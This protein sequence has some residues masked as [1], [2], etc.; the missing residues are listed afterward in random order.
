[1]NAGRRWQTWIRD[2]GLSYSQWQQQ[3]VCQWFPNSVQLTW[4]QLCWVRS[5]DSLVRGRECFC[6]GLHQTGSHDCHLATW[7]PHAS[8]QASKEWTDFP[9]R[10]SIKIIFYLKIHRHTLHSRIQ[11]WYHHQ[12]SFVEFIGGTPGLGNSNLLYRTVSLPDICPR[13][14]HYLYYTGH[15]TCP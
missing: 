6:Q 3:S 9:G 7:A 11:Q 8:G 14:T 5:P 15:Q 4:S 1:M 13:G 10:D 2:K 12:V